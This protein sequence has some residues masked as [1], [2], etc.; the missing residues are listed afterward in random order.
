MEIKPI[1]CAE[2]ILKQNPSLA[3]ALPYSLA[4]KYRLVPLFNN[5]ESITLATDHPNNS[6]GFIWLSWILNKQVHAHSVSEEEFSDLLRKV[7]LPKEA[8]QQEPT[9]RTKHM[10]NKSQAI[11]L[12]SEHGDD[13]ELKALNLLIT[14]AI[15]K[16]ASDIHFEPQENRLCIRL[17]IDGILRPVSTSIQGKKMISRLKVLAKMD[18]TQSRL[19][20]DGRILFLLGHREVDVRASSIP[21]AYGERLVL[22]ILDRQ[23]LH[24]SLLDL[25]IPQQDLIRLKKL[26]HAPEGMLLVTGPTGSGKTTTLYSFLQQ[27]Q[28]EEKNIM[29]IEDPVEYHLDGVAQMNIQDAI[30]LTFAKG[31]RHL[32]RQDPDILM[33]GEVRDEETA[34]IACQSALTGHLVLS[35]LHTN[36]APA[37]ITRL[38]N[39]GIDPILISSTLLAVIAQRLV[40]T[41]CPNCKE[42]APNLPPLMEKSFGK[43][44][45]YQGK[46]CKHCL[47]SGYEGRQAIFEILF[48]DDD[49]RPFIHSGV[50][51]FSLCTKARK[52]G[53]QSLREA[54]LAAAREGR[55]TIEEVIRVTPEF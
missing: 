44:P 3:Q 30:D 2:G 14:E 34:S 51:S 47:N 7:Y 25:N 12:I 13:P 20:Q 10:A 8:S 33:I 16:K 21:T 24:Y 49:I 41:I 4:R 35:T 1:P 42:E 15:E 40:R 5:E 11:D 37:T 32:L 6:E 48:I 18:V 54:G 50:D 23:S 31:L 36:S 45:F 17:R 26:L 29:T 27:I 43:G 46:G 55:T 9:T 19:P 52:Q 38:V 28:S 53:M 39:M 22:R